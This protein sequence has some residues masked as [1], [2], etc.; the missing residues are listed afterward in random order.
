MKSLTQPLARGRTSDPQFRI[1]FLDCAGA[2]IVQVEVCLLLRAAVPKI[3]IRLVPDF[4]IPTL[5]FVLAIAIFRC[6][7]KASI[8]APHLARSRGG[9]GSGLYQNTCGAVFSAS[10]RGMK[11]SSM[12]GLTLFSSRPSLIWST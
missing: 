2:G 6:L 3:D 9:D 4:E 12:N 11:L 5:H 10:L 7:T 1:D 8:S